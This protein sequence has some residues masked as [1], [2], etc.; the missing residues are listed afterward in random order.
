[1]Q[2]LEKGIQILDLFLKART[3][4]GLPEICDAFS[5]P[6]SSVYRYLAV[7]KKHGVV[8]HLKERGKYQLGFRMLEYA[9]LVQSQN[10]LNK[11]ALPYMRR[12]SN[13]AE[14]IVFLSVIANMAAYCLE[15]VEYDRPDRGIIYSMQRGKH[16]PLYCGASAKV[17]LAF[18]PEE[19]IESYLAE[20]KLT[21]YTNNTI[22][23]PQ[24]LREDLAKIRKVG[25]AYSD[26][27][28]DPGARGLSAPIFDYKGKVVAGLCVAGPTHRM[29]KRNISK[30]KNIVV[31]YA[32]DI[33]VKL[34]NSDGGL[35]YR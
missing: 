25:Y 28:A 14:E 10:P 31:Q 24:K 1:M 3:S 33:S 6:R 22:T 18:Q 16:L 9:S 21:K 2:T 32:N 15:R 20:T 12:L 7:F 29:N 27:E 19:E 11:I 34:G 30:L 8:E 26:G 23:D 35:L 13:E 17:L 4:L 5:M